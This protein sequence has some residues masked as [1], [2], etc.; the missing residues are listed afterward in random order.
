MDENAAERQAGDDT[1]H[2]TAG[3]GPTAMKRTRDGAAATSLLNYRPSRTAALAIIV[4]SVLVVSCDAFTPN[5]IG[6]GM[7]SN[8]PLSA[9]LRYRGN[10]GAANKFA[11]RTSPGRPRPRPT[12]ETSR[13]MK[14]VDN[15]EGKVKKLPEGGNSGVGAADSY[16]YNIT[17]SEEERAKEKN[18]AKLREAVNEVKGAAR[19]VKEKTSK[20]KDE[21]M[22]EDIKVVKTPSIFDDVTYEDNFGRKL[23]KYENGK[24]K[25]KKVEKVAATLGEV[26]ESTAKLG[27]TVVKKSPSILGRL[28]LLLVSTDMRKD[29]NRR[30]VHYISDWVD[31]FKNKRQTVP[32]ILFLYFACLSPAVSFG[33]ISSQLTNGSIGVVEF[34]LSCG[35][36]GMAYSVL[37]GQPMAFIAPT[38]LTLAFISGLFRLCT[39]KGLPF[40]PIYAWVG[41]WTS[42]FMISLGMAGSS[43]LIRFC[44]RFTD[45]VFNGLLSLNFIYE[46]ASSLRRN[47]VNA[48]DRSNLTMPFVALTEAL[49]TF[50]ATTKVIAFQTSK[51]F[52]Q[53]VRDTIKNFGPVGVIIA[54][55]LINQV[56]L[57]KSFKVPTLSVA[58][59]FELAGGRD[60]LI[61][62]ASIPMK[63]RLLCAFPA[64]LLTSLFFMD[65]N[66]SV[67][68]INNPDNKLKKGPA[69]NIDMVALGLITAVLS[70]VG[71][72]WMCGATVQ[73]MNHLKAMTTTKFNEETQEAEI[74]H[75][76]E[77]RLTGF[78][79]HALIASTVKALPLLQ[80]LPIPVVSGV[81]LYL[82]RKLM[83]GNTFIERIGDG[84]AESRR[85]PKKHPIQLLG[86]KKMNIFTSLQVA[87]LGG[88]W[89][90]KQNPA[91][92][93]FFPSVIG[94]LIAI[95]GV[96]L[97]RF[98]SEE[99]LVALGD[100]T[101]KRSK[102]K[103][104]IEEKQQQ[105]AAIAAASSS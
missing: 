64:I 48:P 19:V 50:F 96:V 18:K 77:T 61:P 57:I 32:A 86:R 85:L 58:R 20:L 45:E 22:K 93:I 68:V 41:I 9:G 79:I 33:T 51:C 42:V 37:C 78:I 87:C 71:L 101:P 5:G 3:R 84:I 91:T 13:H 8:G 10:V 7:P 2:S 82:G 80:Y 6:G 105:E 46:A 55:S 53:K 14:E 100:P 74:D 28:F 67:R 25:S 1:C 24:P 38:G 40:F 31:G 97:P 66:I 92:A 103:Q 81:F 60:F 30:K 95:R 59:T 47:F 43:R 16:L 35:A 21:V 52:N 39:L 69:Y 17:G 73:S 23:K 70:V 44:T 63:T 4:V 54:M 98:F 34:L 29:L 76:T 102:S 90:F 27:G 36:S 75:V 65:Q 26:T 104:Q 88:L 99:E 56:P 83:I 15:N 11:A 89:T 94:M 12:E 49:F 62:L 72:P